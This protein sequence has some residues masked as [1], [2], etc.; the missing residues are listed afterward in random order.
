MASNLSQ[1]IRQ[2]SIM[3]NGEPFID[4]QEDHQLRC[5]FD[6]KNITPSGLGKADIQIYNLSKDTAIKQRSSI[7]LSAGYKDN[8]GLIFSGTVTNVL[9]ERRGP[10]VITRL[11]CRS[12]TGHNIGLMYGAYTSGTH[13]V[14]VLKDCARSWPL[15]L[16]ID[17]DQF[18]DEDV[19]PSG[20]TAGGDV[21]DALNKLKRMFKFDWIEHNGTLVITR[22]NEERKTPILE[23][24]QRTGM[25][26][27]PEM[28]G[29]LDGYGVDVTSRIN[30]V[31]R[32]DH[33]IKV[34]SEFST[35]STG[36][37]H[38]AELAGDANA[39]GEYNVY[40]MSYYGDTHS[41]AWD[42]KIIAFKA[43][44]M[45]TTNHNLGGG[46]VWGA[47][48]SPEFRAKVREIAARQNLDPNWYMAVM[49]FETGGMFSPEEPNRAG[50]GAV[51]LIQFMPTTADDLGTST[52]KLSR[53]TAVE[54][55]DWVEKYFDQYKYNI[56]NIGDMYIAV[57]MPKYVGFPKSY[58]LIDRDKQPTSYRQ[59]R[60]LDRDEDGK[61]TIAEAEARVI[62]SYN[63]G[64]GSIA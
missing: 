38:V 28:L 21:V 9:K 54:Q 10:D 42:M 3:I 43:G 35:Y 53:M 37:L 44:S 39:N 52:A 31:L 63:K 27:M 34:Q 59:N 16:I 62:Q 45:A 8:F 57:F 51:G 14:E 15:A 46:L 7:T 47:K 18:T 60:G 30:P 64:K 4:E 22:I 29:I 49:A 41:N 50:S 1:Y 26:G 55:L 5:V 56:K 32:P 33:R 2:W 17:E 23:I 6:I 11:L 40:E 61:I 12:S 25:V 58:V 19:F 24:N 48:V 36:N 13:V 20:W